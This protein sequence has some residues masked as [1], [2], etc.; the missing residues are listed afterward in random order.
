MTSEVVT[1]ALALS[2]YVTTTFFGALTI[3]FWCL[4][5]TGEALAWTNPTELLLSCCFVTGKQA[6]SAHTCDGLQ[7]TRSE[8]LVMEFGNWY[9]ITGDY[10]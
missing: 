7:T 1:T 10:T 2:C 8:N 9:S 4:I 6:C 3:P 5:A